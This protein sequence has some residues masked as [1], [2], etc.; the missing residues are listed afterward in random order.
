MR[1]NR[2][3][4]T[5]TLLSLLAFAA[6]VRSQEP[7]RPQGPPPRHREGPPGNGPEQGP[8][9][10]PHSRSPQGERPG[11]PGDGFN[12]IDAEMWYSGKIVK[13]VPYSAKA[14][15]ETSQTLADGTK[16]THQSTALVARDGEGRL[17]REQRIDRL[18]PIEISGEPQLRI[19]IMDPVARLTYVIDP[20]N[21]Q[22][23]KRPLPERPP[24]PP[25]PPAPAGA[26]EDLGKK[27]FEGVEASGTR[28][29]ITIPAG[30][31]GNDRPIQIIEER[32]YSEALQA[33]VYS[34]HSDPRMGENV[35]RLT[36]INLT[37]PSHSLFAVP[38]GYTIRQERMP[39]GPPARERRNPQRP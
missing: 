26:T 32:W 23:Q 36:E 5:A 2:Y 4:I 31:I 11:R 38:E 27:S 16:I 24:G 28:A 3:W 8:P 1:L 6:V 37:E 19:F 33:V 17:R 13:G 34:R 12:L 14:I 39:P 9:G 25:G 20:Q 29:I 7:E 21:R 22:A 18:G 10:E 15:V 35:Y 30:Q